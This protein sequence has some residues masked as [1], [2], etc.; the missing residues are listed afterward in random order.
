MSG[1]AWTLTIG[2]QSELRFGNEKSWFTIL[3]TNNTS[4]DASLVFS[5][6]LPLEFA[7]N[8]NDIEFLLAGS[9]DSVPTQIDTSAPQ[10]TWKIGGGRGIAVS[11]NSYTALKLASIQPV[12][13]G[14]F[15][16]P[17]KWLES[18]NAVSKSLPVTVQ[19]GDDWPTI[20]TFAADDDVFEPQAGAKITLRW[21]VNNADTVLLFRGATQVLPAPGDTTAGNTG[22][23]QDPLTDRITDFQNYQLKTFNKGNQVSDWVFVRIQNPGWNRIPR[24]VEGAPL[25]MVNDN[26]QRLYGVF[27]NNGIASLY[28]LNPSQGTLGAEDRFLKKV[29]PGLETSPGAFFNQRIWIIGGSQ[30]DPN[31]CSNTVWWFDPLTKDSDT[32]QA[33]WKSRMGHAVLAFDG[34]LWVIGGVDAAANTLADVYRSTDG[35]QWTQVTNQVPA[36]CMAGAAAYD[37]R[38]W[39]CG[40][41]DSAFGTPQKFL[42]YLSK[43]QDPSWKDATWTKMKFRGGLKDPSFSELAY[44][45]PFACGLT[46]AKLKGDD[47]LCGIGTFQTQPSGIDSRKFTVKGIDYWTNTADL[48]TDDSIPQSKLW[49]ITVDGS[50][51]QQPFRLTATQFKSLIFAVSL[52]YGSKSTSLSYLVQDTLSQGGQK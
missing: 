5:L 4:S 27:L 38:L 35:K 52:V 31:V 44:G 18:G 12:S 16:L 40:G 26:D 19:S 3:I 49:A 39:L 13:A 45:D 28:Q 29:P 20:G 34:A 25:V 43:G 23:W 37:G 46:P 50:D 33:P 11:A 36:L 2:D 7:A 41:T 30:I 32:A 1:A 21:E 8:I 22:H 6:T 47:V 51:R 14:D 42:W 17:V 48:L 9:D 10:T 24:C 15:Q